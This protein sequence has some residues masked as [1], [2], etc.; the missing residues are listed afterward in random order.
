MYSVLHSLKYQHAYI[1]EGRNGR[2]KAEKHGNFTGAVVPCAYGEWCN[3]Y[4]AGVC[5]AGTP[6]YVTVMRTFQNQRWYKLIVWCET[7]WWATCC[8]RR[9]TS[10]KRYFLERY[11]S[12]VIRPDAAYTILDEGYGKNLCANR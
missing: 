8:D 7:R 12:P 2:S 3:G 5:V 4:R 11:N 1:K 9:W 10:F 6:V